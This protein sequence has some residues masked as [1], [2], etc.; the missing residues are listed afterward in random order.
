MR[1]PWVT[2]CLHLLLVVVCVVGFF[3]NNNNNNNNNNKH[4]R[5][6]TERCFCQLTGRIDDCCCSVQDVDKLNTIYVNS[7]VKEITKRDYFRYVSA[8]YPSNIPDFTSTAEWSASLEQPCRKVMV[9]PLL[10]LS[11]GGWFKDVQCFW[12]RALQKAVGWGY[13]RKR[14]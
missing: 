13:A 8:F 9:I 12:S 10:L 14:R 3:N 11:F 7:R 4:S 2:K 5:R 6:D 1:T